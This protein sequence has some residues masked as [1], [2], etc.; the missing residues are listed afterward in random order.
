[1]TELEYQLRN[2][3]AKLVLAGSDQVA[4][5]L[6][7]ATQAGLSRDRVYLFCD[8]ENDDSTAASSQL[9]APWTDIW[10]P[11]A[12]VE[13]W[14]WKRITSLEEAKGTTAIINYSSGYVND[15]KMIAEKVNPLTVV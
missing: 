3:E 13:S 8:P 2:S 4:S 9:V 14:S 6:K 1:M 5:A 7:A 12:E 10:R 15:D 11:A